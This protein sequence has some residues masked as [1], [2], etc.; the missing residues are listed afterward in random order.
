MANA[1]YSKKCEIYA[2]VLLN[3]LKINSLPIDPRLIAE[4]IGLHV[5][6]E[7]L[8]GFDGCFMRNVKAIIINKSMDSGRKNFT[9]AHEL[10][11]A[12]IPHHTDAEYK[13]YRENLGFPI[14][15]KQE[16][17]EADEFA[18][19]LLMPRELVSKIVT[20][21]KISLDTIKGIAEKCQTSFTSSALAYCKFSPELCAIIVSEAGKIKYF[22]S[23][24]GLRRKN[25]SLVPKMPLNKLSHAM[26]FFNVDGIL[27]N[28]GEEKGKVQNVAWAPELNCCDY[29]CLEHSQVLSNRFN[30]TISLVWWVSNHE[31]NTEED[32]NEGL[33]INRD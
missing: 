7:N 24:E 26:S 27:I 31:D 20:S 23:S 9:I 30:Q 1:I 32:E 21:Q 14:T 19:E 2:T 33:Y 17:R 6:E 16:E 25:I 3:E 22:F 12:R 18:S 15:K 4:R 10:G 11:H 28:N 13:E 8:S 5:V 29:T